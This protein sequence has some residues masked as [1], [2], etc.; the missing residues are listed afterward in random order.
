MSVK[1]AVP[2]IQ[3]GV[4]LAK[5]LPLVSVPAN[6]R[7]QRKTTREIL[8]ILHG[9][10]RMMAADGAYAE[11]GKGRRQ[12]MNRAVTRRQEYTGNVGNVYSD[13]RTAAVT[14]DPG[15]VAGPRAVK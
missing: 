15:F 6:K 2:G 1:L 7:S 4:W 10:C 5:L 8:E 11:N 3:Q 12:G 9:P 14:E 13:M